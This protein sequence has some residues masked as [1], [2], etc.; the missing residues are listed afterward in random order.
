MQTSTVNIR[1]GQV[2]DVVA[3]SG[4]RVG[5]HERLG[6][7][8]EVLGQDDHVHYRVAWDDGAETVFYPGSDAAIR[9]SGAA[10]TR[11]SQ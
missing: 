2:G 7:I 5:E 1:S 3:V 11:R 6:E 4:H 8:L 10:G 9:R